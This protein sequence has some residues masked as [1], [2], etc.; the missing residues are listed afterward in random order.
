LDTEIDIVDATTISSLQ[1]D[2]SE[3]QSDIPFMMKDIRKEIKKVKD[4]E[5]EDV[6]KTN[7]KVKTKTNKFYRKV[8]EYFYLGLDK[9]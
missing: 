6:F 1:A 4:L 8:K 7:M 5:R 2:Q 9:L 3:L